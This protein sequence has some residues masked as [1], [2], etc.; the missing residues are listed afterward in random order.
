MSVPAPGVVWRLIDALHRPI[1]QP[2][3]PIELDLAD[4]DWLYEHL[5]ELATK[6]PV[7]EGK[8]PRINH[9]LWVAVHVHMI[10]AADRAKKPRKVAYG[11]AA[12]FWGITEKQVEEW[13][14]K[15]RAEAERTVATVEP[16]ALARL[17]KRNR[18][19]YRETSM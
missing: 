7:R 14:R 8:P 11:E 15:L 10:R 1:D 13:E 9:C 5:L 3:G 18:D 17:I 6:P 4:G 19:V 2:R 12:E 16:K